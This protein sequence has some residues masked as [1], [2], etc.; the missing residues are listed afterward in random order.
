LKTPA[1]INQVFGCVNHNPKA[2][3][4]MELALQFGSVSDETVKYGYGF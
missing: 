2:V 1:L 3:G 4:F